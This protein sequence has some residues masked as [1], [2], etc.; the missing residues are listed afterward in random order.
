MES[1][2]DGAVC[3]YSSTDIAVHS[4]VVIFQAAEGIS[5]GIE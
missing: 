2:K 1:A 4:S 3:F 5:G